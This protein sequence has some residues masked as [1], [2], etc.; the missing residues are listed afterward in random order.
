M[1]GL[2][3]VNQ[4]LGLLGY[5]ENDGNTQLTQRVMNS[6]LPSFNLV[7]TDLC[8][9]CDLEI[10]RINNLSEE[11]ELPD[12]ALDILICGVASYIA[13]AEGDEN[14]QY[15][16][17]GEYKARRTTLTKI[18]EYKDVLPTVEL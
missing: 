10:K 7:Y 17:S 5:A 11:V 15:F 4:A 13:G 9:I 2:N 14:M 8:R 6:V 16:W 18:T 12:K 3:V 1:T